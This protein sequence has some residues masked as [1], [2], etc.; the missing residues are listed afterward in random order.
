METWIEQAVESWRVN[1]RVDL[2]LL[3]AISLDAL[4]ESGH[5]LDD[6][7]LYGQW[8]WSMSCN[9]FIA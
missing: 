6:A 8:E 7:V 4:T 5:K 1:H 2:Y 3:D 9:S